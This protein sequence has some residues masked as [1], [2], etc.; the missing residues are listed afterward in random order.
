MPL[1]WKTR[2]S[3]GEQ[4]PDSVIRRVSQ[5]FS[6]VR[7]ARAKILYFSAKI[8]GRKIKTGHSLIGPQL[9]HRSP[10]AAINIGRFTHEMSG[11][12]ESNPHSQL[13]RLELYH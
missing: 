10:C 1:V 3:R 11:Q 5:R 4:M 9:F 2:N 8:V 12:R 6:Y 7:G 13:G